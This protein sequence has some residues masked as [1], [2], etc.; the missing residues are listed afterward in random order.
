MGGVCLGWEDLLAVGALAARSG[1]RRG[2]QWAWF[3]E[4]ASI[5]AAIVTVMDE[6]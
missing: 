2:T 4:W 3:G 5:R 6:F 1:L